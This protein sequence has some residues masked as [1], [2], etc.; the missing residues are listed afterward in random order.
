MRP[1]AG[2]SDPRCKMFADRLAA[3]WDDDLADLEARIAWHDVQLPDQR[4]P[5]GIAV[6]EFDIDNDGQTDAVL[7]ETYNSHA[8]MGERYTVFPADSWIRDVRAVRDARESMRLSK[9]A[10]READRAMR[11]AI[12]CQ[13]HFPQVT[14]IRSRS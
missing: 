7:R 4:F 2:I 9:R 11:M 14:T 5:S 12:A 6:A 13:I 1:L 8:S 3:K 10:R